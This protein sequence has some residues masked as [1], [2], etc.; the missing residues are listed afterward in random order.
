MYA[1]VEV[2]GKQYKVEK[3]SK[4]LI[5][6]LGENPAVPEIKALLVKKDDE[7]V[8][9]G[10]PYVSGVTI[11]A[12]VVGERKGD[13]VLV[14][15]YKKRKDYRRLRGHRQKYHRLLIEDIAV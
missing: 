14:F 4:I 10:A 9:I 13:K 2:K 6:Y 7:S 3:G 15:K 12:K 8:S 11:T 5:D 1:I